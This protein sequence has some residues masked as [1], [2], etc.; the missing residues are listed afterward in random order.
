MQAR[1]NYSWDGRG[2]T[3]CQ[4]KHQLQGADFYDMNPAATA[5]TFINR[6]WATSFEMPKTRNP[7]L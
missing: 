1:C 4:E 5:A 6:N 7:Q 2:L 3:Q